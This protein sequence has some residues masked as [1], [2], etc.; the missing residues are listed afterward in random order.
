MKDEVQRVY[1]TLLTRVHRKP[2]TAPADELPVLIGSLDRPVDKRDRTSAPQ[3][4]C[5]GGLH[6]HA[7]VLIP[8]T[9]RL[10]ETLVD[11]FEANPGLY[12]GNGIQRVHVMPADRDYYRI[13]DYVLKTV[14]LNGRLAYD[15]VVIVLPRSKGELQ[16]SPLWDFLPSKI[17]PI[18]SARH[19]AII[20]RP[21]IRRRVVPARTQ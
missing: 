3:V 11:H 1:S 20:L 13:T 8:P 7:V 16:T 19:R 10:K 17:L 15:D 2:R 6:V 5:N 12:V 14:V 21:S 9:S 4:L 18:S